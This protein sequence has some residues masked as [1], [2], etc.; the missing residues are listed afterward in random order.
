MRSYGFVAKK[1]FTDVQPS[2]K[3]YKTDLRT[4]PNSLLKVFKA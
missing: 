4:L 3:T 1:P 2:S